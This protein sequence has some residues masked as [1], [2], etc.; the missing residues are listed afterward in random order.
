MNNFVLLQ[1]MKTFAFIILILTL[2]S[3]S[4]SLITSYNKQNGFTTS[5]QQKGRDLLLKAQQTVNIGQLNNYSSY[6]VKFKDCFYGFSGFFA[7]PYKNKCSEFELS[8]IPKTFNGLMAFTSGKQK[9]LNVG[10][11]DWKT[12]KIINNDTIYKKDKKTEFW[13][14][15]YQYFI[16]LPL[17]ILEA[18]KICYAGTKQYNNRQYNLVMATW[19]TF[20]P[21][22]HLDQYLIWISKST[23]RIE[24]VQYTIRDMSKLIKGTT[25]YTN[26]KSFNGIML[27]TKML[28]SAL[29]RQKSSKWNT[30]K[31]MHSMEI[32]DVIF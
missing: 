27:P 19:N 29:S 22:K 16:E 12:F 10:L 2:T 14:P 7:N 28:V 17:R 3:C 32:L 11:K 4:S 9:G 21:Q 1:L 5:D 13:L 20:Q 15:T 25:F 26:Y 23:H 18:D 6:K 30:Q 24:I 8:L 31:L